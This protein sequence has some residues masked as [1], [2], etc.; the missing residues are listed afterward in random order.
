MKKLFLI[1]G[2]GILLSLQL[3]AGNSIFSYEGYPVRFFCKDIYSLGM[4]DVGSTDSFRPNNGFANP[5]LHNRTASTLFSTG[6]VM[7]Y[8]R[9]SSDFDTLGVKHFTDNSL[10]LPYFSLSVPYK[11]HRFGFQFNSYASGLVKNQLAFKDSNN[12]TVTEYQSMDRYMYRADLIY[13]I[14][15]GKLSLGVSGNFLLGHENRSFKQESGS[16]IFNTAESVTKSY[17]NP[18]A[19]FG[20]ID[21][22]DWYSVGM[23]YTLGANLKGE[24][25]RT[26]IHE[27]ELATDYEMEV[28]SQFAAGLTLLPRKYFKLAMD[29]SYEDWSGISDNYVQSYK[30]GIGAAYEPQKEQYYSKLGKVPYRGGLSWRK[31]PFKDS[32]GNEIDELSLSL[33]LTLPLKR[34]VNRVD[35]GFQYTRRGD[36]TTNKLRD[37]AFMLMV[38]FTGFDIITKAADR[39]APREI[40]VAED[41]KAW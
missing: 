27:T 35:F 3:Y 40:P 28:P 6:M 2:L 19:T 36:L 5:A 37:D 1:M 39:K 9:Y 33:G 41:I 7:G 18:T 21:T 15:L 13:N 10:D 34:D 30:I 38:G 22:G 16:G 26:S 29:L 25:Q 12:V 32:S 4:G 24:Q 8:T 31:L 17:K 14:L 20:I 23:H 11:K